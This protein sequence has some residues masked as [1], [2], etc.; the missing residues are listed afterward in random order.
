[1]LSGGRSGRNDADA[2]RDAGL[3]GRAAR[4][5]RWSVPDRWA[6]RVSRYDAAA[7]RARR[8]RRRTRRSAARAAFL[9]LQRAV[10]RRGGGSASPGGGAASAVHVLGRLAVGDLTVPDAARI[11]I[12]P[13]PSALAVHG[14]VPTGRPVGRPPP[15]RLVDCV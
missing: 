3:R 9:F 7:H 15:R 8:R 11:G 6:A 12:A 13:A 4:A 14:A 5:G 1:D 10:V 2:E